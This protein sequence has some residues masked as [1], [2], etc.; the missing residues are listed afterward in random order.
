MSAV[1]YQ[2]LIDALEAFGCHGR[3]S[4][5]HAQ[6]TCPVHEDRT[7]SLSITDKPDS[8]LVHDHAGCDILD[9]L[10]AVGLDWPD[11]F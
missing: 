3:D 9:I 11:L 8:V 10:E 2:R 7:P 4:G 5:D 6:Y 1:A